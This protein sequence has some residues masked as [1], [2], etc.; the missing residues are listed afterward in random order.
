MNPYC[1]SF[2]PAMLALVSTSIWQ[3]SRIR[4]MRIMPLV[5]LALLGCHEKPP[6]STSSTHV[7]DRR[8]V[9]AT[10]K[11]AVEAPRS[12]SSDASSAPPPGA[13]APSSDS[14]VAPPPSAGASAL[15][16]V[17][18]PPG[19]PQ[20]YYPR[21]PKPRLP[22]SADRACR[23]DADCG[24]LPES[25]RHCPP[26]N[27]TW[28]Q[29][30]NKAAVRRARRAYDHRRCPPITCRRCKRLP[31]PPGYLPAETG[32]IGDRAVCKTGQCVVE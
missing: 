2:G 14:A 8:T 17:P 15:N 21:P 11:Q 19:S 29:P 7:G 3:R 6:P 28:R 24:L 20:H 18:A 4:P 25:C 9:K 12:P 1:A 26:C 22:W 16:F 13:A 23:R 31:V 10:G 27:P 5:C 30:A 32:Y